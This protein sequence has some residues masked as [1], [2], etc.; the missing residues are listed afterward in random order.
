M[1]K[2][3]I[4]IEWLSGA[5]TNLCYNAVDRNVNEGRGDKV[6][7]YWEGNDVGV[8]GSWTYK[9]LLDEVLYFSIFPN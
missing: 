8:S 1:N 5:Q 9:Q 6:A 2:G 7:F 4:H 3:P